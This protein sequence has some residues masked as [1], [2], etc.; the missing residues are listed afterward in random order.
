A[1]VVLAGWWF[2][3][4]GMQAFA[5]TTLVLLGLVVW[6][7]WAVPVQ[8]PAVHVHAVGPPIAEV[9]RRPE[10]RWFFASVFLTV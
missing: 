2:Q 3:L 1:S 10:V 4:F 7:A 8:A 9:M 5:G 6:T